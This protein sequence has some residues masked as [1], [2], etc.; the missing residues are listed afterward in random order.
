VGRRR[1]DGGALDDVR[2]DCAAIEVGRTHG[3]DEG[4]DAARR[5]VHRRR[6]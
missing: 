5:S 3:R 1:L 6:R 2:G 4:T